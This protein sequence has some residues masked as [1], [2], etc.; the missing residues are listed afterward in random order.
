MIALPVLEDGRLVAD[1]SIGTC[2]RSN[3]TLYTTPGQAAA[4]ETKCNP[5]TKPF[6]RER[7]VSVIGCIQ[8]RKRSNRGSGMPSRRHSTSI[9]RY[10]SHSPESPPLEPQDGKFDDSC[11]FLKKESTQS[12]FPIVV[13]SVPLLGGR[14]SRGYPRPLQLLLLQHHITSSFANLRWWP[15]AT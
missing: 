13:A 10:R 4:C 12:C 14:P 6:A 7:N 2:Q 3:V 8:F 9:C 5:I 1:T 15:L 11:P